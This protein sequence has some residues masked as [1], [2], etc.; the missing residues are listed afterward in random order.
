MVETARFR[1]ILPSRQVLLWGAGFVL[2]FLFNALVEL[3]FLPLWGL[4][5]T[6]RNDLYFKA[7][8]I[9]VVL[10]FFCGHRL[11]NGLVRSRR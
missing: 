10:W 7:W 9:A 5:D 1:M 8:W 11:L 3:V 2:L 6:P 4:D